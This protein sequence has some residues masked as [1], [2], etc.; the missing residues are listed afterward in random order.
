MITEYVGVINGV[1]T[2]IVKNDAG[3]VIGKNETPEVSDTIEENSF[4]NEQGL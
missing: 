2:W 3:E 1:K 4:E